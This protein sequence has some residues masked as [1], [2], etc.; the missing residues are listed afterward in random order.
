MVGVVVFHILFTVDMQVDVLAEAN[1]HIG[2]GVNR[3]DIDAVVQLLGKAVAVLT[4]NAVELAVVSDK[5][6]YERY[7]SDMN[8][9]FHRKCPFCLVG[10]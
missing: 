9:G 5:Q 2:D 10:K 3:G 7:A 6:P 8:D 1:V 4:H